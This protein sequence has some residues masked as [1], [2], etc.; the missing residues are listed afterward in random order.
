MS[1]MPCLASGFFRAARVLL[2][3]A[4]FVV[5]TTAPAQA[6]DKGAGGNQAAP[7]GLKVV[8][9]MPRGEVQ[10]VTQVT[11]RFSK[12][13]RPLGDMSQPVATAPLKL[14]PRPAGQY[15]WLDPQTL[16]YILKKPYSGATR[17]TATIPAGTASLDGTKLRGAYRAQFRTPP[18][19]WIKVSPSKKKRLNPVPQF[20]ITFNQPVVIKSLRKRLVLYVGGKKVKT[21]LRWLK[22]RQGGYRMPKLASYYEVVSTTRLGPDQKA[23]LRIRPGVR[24]AQGTEASK[25]NYAV[26]YQT[27]TTLGVDKWRM[28][29]NPDGRLDPEAGLTLYFTNPVSP[30]EVWKRLSFDPPLKPKSKPRKSPTRWVSIEVNFK[31]ATTYRLK[32]KPGLKGSFGTTMKKG[33]ELALDIG[34]LS[35]VFSLAASKGVMEVGPQALYPLRLRNV[36]Q[37][38][39]ALHF[40]NADN[41]VPALIAAEARPWGKAPPWPDKGEDGVSLHSLSFDLARNQTHMHMLDLA[42]LLG[43]S[44]R[45]GVTFLD[46]RTMLPNRKG[47]MVERSRNLFVQVTDLALSLKF[48]EASSLAWVTSLNEGKPISGVELELRD[49]TNKVLW[50]GTSDEHGT[51]TL[52]SLAELKP[53]KDPDSNWRAPAVFLIAKLGD[54][55]SVLPGSWG[56]DL[57]YSLPSKVSIR[58]PGAGV[59]LA[60]HAVT[61][62]PLYQPGQTVRMAVYLRRDSQEGLKA[63]AGQEIKLL[64]I[65]PSG[66]ELRSLKATADDYGSVSGEITLGSAARLGVY[67]IK[68][69]VDKKEIYAGSFRVASFRP[70]DF[71]LTMQT[72]PPQ[73][74]LGPVLKA[75]VQAMYHFGTPLAGV[76]AVLQASQRSSG[77][78]PARLNDY[79]V[80][81]VPLPGKE[82]AISQALG[83]SEAKLDS[84]GR[85]ALAIPKPKPQPGYPVRVLLETKV[86]DASQRQVTARRTMLVHPS[87]VY[88]G[89]KT[90]YLAKVNKPAELELAVAGYDNKVLSATPVSVTVYRQLWETVREKGPGGFYRTVSK[91]RRIKAWSG[92]AYVGEKGA[93]LKF[94]PKESGTFVAVASTK[95]AQGRANTSGVYFYAAGAKEA[96]WERHDDH[97]L[98]LVSDDVVLAPGQSARI[99]IKNP[100][101]AATALVTIERGGVRRVLVRQVTGPAPVIEVPVRAADAPAVYAGVLLV[102]GRSAPPAGKGPDLGKPQV[103]IGYVILKVK[104]PTAGLKVK[105]TTD[106]AKVRPGAKITANVAVTDTSGSP[107]K[108]QVILLAVDERVLSAASGQNNYDP[109]KTFGQ[110]QPLAILTADMRTQVLGRRFKGKKGEDAAG[111]GAAAAPPLRKKFH[112]AVFWLALAETDDQGQLSATFTL[113]DTLTAYRV[114]AVAADKTRN[115]GVG[116]TKVI[117]TQPLQLL[118]ALPRFAVVGDEFMARV[119]VQNLSNEPGQVVVRAKTQGMTI[120][121]PSEKKVIVSPGQTKTVGFAVA[122]GQGKSAWLEAEARMG[123]HADRARFQFPVV[124]LT[125][126]THAAAAGGLNPAAGKTQADIPLKLPA[127]AVKGRGGIKV[128]ISPSLASALK[129][130]ATVVMAYPWDCLEQRTSKAAVRGLRLVSGKRLGLAPF[131][132]DKKALAEAMAMVGEFQTGGGGLTLWPGAGRPSL[133]VTAYV[134]LVNQEIAGS[135]IG[136]DQRV[137]KN[138]VAY[139]VRRLRHSKAPKAEHL[140]DRVAEAAAILALAREGKKVKDA[141]ES[142]ARRYKG[143]SPFGLGAL[144]EAA[145]LMKMDSLVAK[146]IIELES[147]AEVS[148][149]HLHFTTI[150]PSGL[151]AV[152]GSRLRGNAMAL[153]ALSRA[154][155]DYPRLDALARWVADRLGERRHLTTQESIFG[156]W[157]LAA[158]IG[159]AGETTDLKMAVTVDGRNMLEHEYTS[160]KDAP[161]TVAV[162]RD[163]LEPGKPTKVSISAQG[164]GRPHWTVRLS[165]APRM[166]SDKAVGA[167]FH[168]SRAYRIKGDA[169]ATAPGLGKQVEVTL[170]LQVSGSRHHVLVYD[171]FPAGLEPPEPAAGPPSGGRNSA[172]YAWQWRELRRDRLLLYARHLRPGVYTFTYTLRAVAPGNFRMKRARAEEMYAPE[173]F[174]LSTGG[175]MK[176][177]DG[178]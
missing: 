139:L 52:P 163:L 151:K 10:R 143:L 3:L 148:A 140:W 115:F 150:S 92:A 171:P 124:P 79:A 164:S 167:G 67:R 13:M 138:A 136:L 87:A 78:A 8:S 23:V 90:S 117:A 91:A 113:P 70:P 110:L 86:S 71:K 128:V 81:A 38:R 126:L 120:I 156:L 169:K 146:L 147:T 37:A 46:I 177:K 85:A 20:R 155:P 84:S 17:F 73:V 5:F 28:A 107:L 7:G 4:A 6:K 11:V 111:G 12:P 44:P 2:Y 178:K 158:Y 63:A 83:S 130:P 127:D 129:R 173:V 45:G 33:Y 55:L 131:S 144:I 9:F 153:L 75:N 41:I 141:L 112:P 29:K 94:T 134:L 99:M 30:A 66:R 176:I 93:M 97:R 174:G 122:I 69:N 61:Q 60:A 109:R 121:G 152:M 74:G 165:Y 101:K 65:D 82:P 32:L 161:V 42:K 36:S 137:R 102:R 39:A 160:P 22:G 16:A 157:G 35:P 56:E 98:E 159:K 31:P 106:K 54:D 105:V 100:F 119:L 18:V 27:Y 53:K 133:Y 175:Y 96:G 25:T 62:L 142:T 50:S 14:H 145:H 108:A 118:S 132:G 103:R 1:A 114:V 154:R 172:T 166:P 49:R 47:V 43:R 104:D 168:L 162:L 57:Q 64:V 95:D 89:I 116:R 40:Y 68:V 80:G 48:G 51:A 149:A 15:R 77:F 19:K 135:G 21:N 34:D 58:T 88:V 72:P 170:T 24:P 26:R 76:E 123:P 125:Q 59:D